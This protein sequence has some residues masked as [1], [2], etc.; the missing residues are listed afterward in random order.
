MY[1]AKYPIHELPSAEA[2]LGREEKVA[3]VEDA[4]E[5]VER[6]FV[7]GTRKS[8]AS[9]GRR[10]YPHPT[11]PLYTTFTH[12]HTHTHRLPQPIGY[13]HRA[14]A[15]ILLQQVSHH[16]HH[17]YFS[18]PSPPT[19]TAVPIYCTN[20][21]FIH[22]ISHPIHRSYKYKIRPTHPIGQNSPSNG[23][24]QKQLMR[25]SH[26][27]RVLISPPVYDAP[28]SAHTLALCK[29][30]PCFQLAEKARLRFQ[31]SPIPDLIAPAI[32]TTIYSFEEPPSATA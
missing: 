31:I 12:T 22:N 6:S 14:A 2:L 3:H 19:L 16:L 13:N 24:R 20:I 28:P 9:A 8:K 30:P 7:F 5:D 4:K 17:T 23:Q 27:K 1:T 15:T 26:L 32:H 25:T 29:A 18:P 21:P 11:N 10:Q